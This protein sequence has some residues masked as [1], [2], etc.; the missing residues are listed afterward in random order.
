[1]K[2]V[3]EKEPIWMYLD[4]Y[5]ALLYKSGNLEEALIYADKAIAAGEEEKQE[6]ISS[7]KDLRAKIEKAINSR[8]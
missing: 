1:M 3:I 6:D 2:P 5:A 7:T 4:T 8:E